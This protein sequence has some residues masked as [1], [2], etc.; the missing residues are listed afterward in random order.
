MSAPVNPLPSPPQGAET[1]LASDRLWLRP[2]ADGDGALYAAL[3]GDA[4]V[5]RHVR[6]PLAPA[7]AARSFAIALRQQ[8]DP[9]ATRRWWVLQ[10]RD[11]TRACG[12]LGLQLETGSAELG[13]LLHPARQGRGLARE[14]LRRLCASVFE[15]RGLRHLSAR[16]HP[17]NAAA[18]RLFAAAGFLALPTPACGERHWRLDAPP[19]VPATTAP[20]PAPG[21]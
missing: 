4:D 2:L 11:E 9:R 10:P 19:A 21:R 15:T 6:A 16:H 14:A 17:D 5:M 12:L 13:I 1:T 18:A 3:Y 7:E 20:K 8:R